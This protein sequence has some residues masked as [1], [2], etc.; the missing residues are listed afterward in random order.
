MRII[1]GVFKSRLIKISSNDKSIRPTT[2]RARES[3]FNI[4]S[5][6]I[7]FNGKTCLNLFCGTGSIGL[8]CIS[9]VAGKALFV[10]KRIN[11]VKENINTL[12]VEN[13]S[14]VI[15]KDAVIF[16]KND[17][18]DEFDIAFADPPYDF[19]RYRVLIDEISN[20]KILFILEHSDKFILEGMHKEKAFSHKKFGDTNFT[21]FDFG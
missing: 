10:D 5:N 13:K 16:L 19:K 2:D 1:S 14:I 18:K 17:V 21:F 4:L 12:G 3:L 6:K 11:N 9:R 7:D 15:K 20:L 8:E